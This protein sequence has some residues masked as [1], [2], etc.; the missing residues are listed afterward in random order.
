M[1]V[2][3]PTL[4]GLHTGNVYSKMGKTYVLNNVVKNGML[5]V[6]IARN[7]MPEALEALVITLLI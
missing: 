6:E 2:V 3:K 1:S 4:D 5:L 7:I